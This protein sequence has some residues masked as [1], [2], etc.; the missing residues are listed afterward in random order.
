MFFD[1]A[2]Q[3][4]QDWVLSYDLQ[5]QVVLAAR[6]QETGSRLQFGWLPDFAVWW[7]NFTRAGSAA[8]GVALGIL[9]AATLLVLSWPALA[10]LWRHRRRLRRVVRGQG[11]ASDAT[12]LYERMLAMLARRGFKK[13]PWLTPS[14]FANVLPQSEISLV[15]EDLTRAYNQFRFGGRRD[16]APRMLLLLEQLEG[17]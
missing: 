13:P 16:V 3:F 12:M 2:D 8:L 11:Q 10:R 4:W 15:V 6:V 7:K 14:E 1:A 5:R 17:L 9:A